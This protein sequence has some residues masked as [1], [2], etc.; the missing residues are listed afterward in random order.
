MGKPKSP[1]S[2]RER[3]KEDVVL[4]A[5]AGKETSRF[6]LSWLTMP[7]LSLINVQKFIRLMPW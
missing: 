6:F 2:Y 4:H 1:G 5:G 3:I 7:Q